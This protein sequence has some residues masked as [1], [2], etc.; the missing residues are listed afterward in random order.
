[1][2]GTDASDAVVGKLEGYRYDDVFARN[3]T[4]RAGDHRVIHDVYL[5]EVKPKAEVTTAWDYEK[6]L[7]TIPA[8][9]AF[10]PETAGGCTL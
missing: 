2:T 1:M 6:I 9:E 4:V 3:A 7:R 10:R 5:A 8:A